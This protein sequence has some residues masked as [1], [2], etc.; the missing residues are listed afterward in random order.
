MATLRLSTG[1]EKAREAAFAQGG[2]SRFFFTN[3]WYL[4]AV[5]LRNMLSL[6]LAE[7]Y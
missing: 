2:F 3:A 5:F 7:L 4:L 1:K 6:F